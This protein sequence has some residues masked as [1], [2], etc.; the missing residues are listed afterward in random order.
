MSVHVYSS[1]FCYIFLD[2]MLHYPYI[3]CYKSNSSCH[4]TLDVFIDQHKL[5]SCCTMLSCLA[6]KHHKHSVWVIASHPLSTPSI[7]LT[8]NQI[9]GWGWGWGGWTHLKLSIVLNLMWHNIKM[10]RSL[11]TANA[12]FGDALWFRYGFYNLSYT[13]IDPTLLKKKNKGTI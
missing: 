4:R 7:F 1:L 6:R 2:R 9:H 13:F 3:C 11:W 12:A 8:V 10:S 5:H